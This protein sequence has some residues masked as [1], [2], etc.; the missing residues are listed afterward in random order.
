MGGYPYGV[1]ALFPKKDKP[2]TYTCNGMIR[3]RMA[4]PAH[5]WQG[6]PTDGEVLGVN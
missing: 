6:R 5:G 2:P 3:P 1:I 4:R